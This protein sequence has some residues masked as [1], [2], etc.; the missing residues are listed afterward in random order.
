MR[1]STDPA[2]TAIERA[3]AGDESA[4]RWIVETHSSDMRQVAFVVCGDLDLAEEAVAVAWPIA[5][6]KLRS[7]R[8]P[9][10]LRPWLVSIAANEARGLVQLRARRAVREIAVEA[11]TDVDAGSHVVSPH[12]SLASALDLANALAG[13]RPAD[14][15]LLALRYVAGLN[16]TE[17]ARVTGLTPAGTRARLKRLL[18]HMRR[19]L[20]DD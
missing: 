5:W 3:L 15:S 4:F 13:L 16:S 10:S 9:G 19:E 18:Q 12:G 11:V 20:G 14:R 8:E 2:T 1:A 6:R 7:L 17:L